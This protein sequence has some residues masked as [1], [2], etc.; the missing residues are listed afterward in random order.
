MGNQLGSTPGAGTG[1]FMSD[2][3][4]TLQHLKIKMSYSRNLGGGKIVKSMLCVYNNA[5]YIVK[6]YVNRH[7]EA[8]DSKIKSSITS[9]QE[10]VQG[11]PN[12]VFYQYHS[13]ES[14][15]EFSGI[16]AIRPYFAFSL[17]DRFHTHPYLHDIE[18]K[19]LVYQLLMGIQALH[20]RNI[21][22][23]DLKSENILLTSWNWIF[24]SDIGFYKPEVLPADNPAEYT[25]FYVTDRR[26]RCYIAPERFFSKRDV[27]SSTSPNKD[28]RN[29]K[30]LPSSDIFSAGCI[31]AEI[32]MDGEPLFDHAAILRYRSMNYDLTPQLNKIADGN[33]RELVQSMTQLT[34]SNRLSAKEYL[35]LYSGKIFPKYFSILYDIFSRILKPEF[36]CSDSKIELIRNNYDNLLQSIFEESSLLEVGLD[37]PKP[38][39]LL[40]ETATSAAYFHSLSEKQVR[41]QDDDPTL[42]EPEMR[43]LSRISGNRSSLN[44]ILS[45]IK[46]KNVS[47]IDDILLKKLEAYIKNSDSV[48]ERLADDC[49]HNRP[50]LDQDDIEISTL[51]HSLT[52]SRLTPSKVV[53]KADSHKSLDIPASFSKIRKKCSQGLIPLIS[54]LSC[55]VRAAK[56]MESKITALEIMNEF[57]N[58]VE[59]EI[60]LGRI[61]PYQ[62]SLLSS[63]DEKSKLQ[64]APALVRAAA[65]K[66]MTDTLTSIQE[67]SPSDAKIFPEYIFPSLLESYSSG[68]EIVCISFAQNLAR[69]SE[70][71]KRFL[72]MSNFVKLKESCSE[73]SSDLRAYVGSYDRELAI[74]QGKVLKGVDLVLNST[75]KVKIALLSDITRLGVFLGR[76]RLNDSLLPKLFTILNDKDWWIKV[77]FLENIVGISVF[78]GQVS[79]HNFILPCIEATISDPEEFVV[80]KSLECL[81]SLCQA[82]MLADRAIEMLSSIIC[83]LLS[84]PNSWIRR[85]TV[86]L[87]LSMAE[88]LGAA[89]A[90]CYLCPK[91][92]PFCSDEIYFI[93]RETLLYCLKPPISRSSYNKYIQYKQ[94]G[95]QD[96]LGDLNLKDHDL[97]ILA[98]MQPYIDQV[99]QKSNSHERTVSVAD[100]MSLRHQRSFEEVPLHKVFLQHTISQEYLSEIWPQNKDPIHADVANQSVTSFSKSKNYSGIVERLHARLTEKLDFSSSSG[101]R[102][103]V[104]ESAS[105]LHINVKKALDIS[106]KLL[107]FGFLE[108]D[109]LS[110][111]PFFQ[112]HRPP[113]AIDIPEASRPNNWTPRGVLVADLNEHKGSV[114]RIS[115]SRDN[116]FMV[117]ASDDGTVKIWDAQKLEKA[118]ATSQLTYSPQDGRFLDVVVCDCSHSFAAV[119]SNGSV[120]LVKTSFSYK[121]KRHDKYVGL[122]VVQKIN[123]EE[124]AALAIDHFNTISES[125]LVYG[126]QKGI[127]HAWDLRA[128][129]EPW[130]LQLPNYVGTIC[131]LKVGPTQFCLIAGTSRGFIIVWDLRFQIPIQIWRH[132]LKKPISL[133]YSTESSSILPPGGVQHPVSGPL[134][135]V[136]VHGANEVCAYDLYTGESRACF[137]VQPSVSKDTFRIAAKQSGSRSINASSSFSKSRN[138][139]TGINAANLTLPSLFP[140]LHKDTGSQTLPSDYLD[141]PTYFDEMT[142]D[143]PH[144]SGLLCCEQDFLLTAGADSAIRFWNLRAD[145]EDQRP[146]YRISSSRTDLSDGHLFF[147]SHVENSTLL[148]EE[149]VTREQFDMF[150][151]DEKEIEVSS[152]EALRDSPSTAG[153]DRPQSNLGSEKRFSGKRRSVNARRRGPVDP[154]THHIDAITDLKAFEF[155]QK[156][157]ISSSR[158][159]NIKVWV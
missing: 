77:A 155:P 154:P 5:R 15:P 142:E 61:V 44:Y 30:A 12:V 19:W 52:S 136:S 38:Y 23:R 126:T 159:G 103:V 27:G 117:S 137:R 107:D 65:I 106:P 80:S 81:F 8:S 60:R 82:G 133:I 110:K 105:K 109:R 134:V 94:N 124:G 158:N 123:P 129:R 152:V 24:I 118:D 13:I 146:S 3:P 143:Q 35:D 88:K 55:S 34:Y 63:P 99:L 131:Q 150:G 127:V 21:V 144:M 58:L 147:K 102:Q 46:S 75:S 4:S 11:I 54:L 51:R 101:S 45:S 153:E 31:I 73:D 53:E 104:E 95:Q 125:L 72:S 116:V 115:V 138:F 57:G 114:N 50:S 148:Y 47:G 42:L 108:V 37:Y 97:D 28:F 78:V 112:N 69:L 157:L 22:H 6:V 87:I 32:F 76:E 67:I 91:L 119:S 132:S 18:K 92:R 17:Y 10:A 111:S 59:D 2:L 70:T 20:D 128:K 84:H 62:I 145:L 120:H 149:I 7:L 49:R 43:S 151:S 85:A 25:T 89:K 100:E 139:S 141:I 121:D 66:Y 33:V 74:L 135:F 16:F 93:D 36:N 29:S 9:L 113:Y 56:S 86:T 14:S 1:L 39:T 48:V 79:F 40:K 71:A 64:P 41:S 140:Y 96:S 156:M 98:L 130:T 90:H 68:D 83:P 26:P 122:S